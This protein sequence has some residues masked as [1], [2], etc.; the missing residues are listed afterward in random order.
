MSSSVAELQTASN[1][2]DV[3]S[4]ITTERLVVPTAKELSVVRRILGLRPINVPASR[5]PGQ[6]CR[7]GQEPTVNIYALAPSPTPLRVRRP[8]STSKVEYALDR[9]E[10]LR[11]DGEIQCALEHMATKD[12]LRDVNETLRSIQESIVC[13]AGASRVFR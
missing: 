4:W 3:L 11:L 6:W 13:R 2:Q 1:Y 7:K 5:N 10:Y 9:E 12:E 8:S